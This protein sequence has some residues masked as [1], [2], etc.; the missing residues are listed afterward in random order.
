LLER[1]GRCDASECHYPHGREQAERVGLQ[2]CQS[3]GTGAIPRL[4]STGEQNF[5][6]RQPGTTGARS[7]FPCA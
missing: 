2:Q 4:P 6:H 1:H 7:W 3:A 5:Q